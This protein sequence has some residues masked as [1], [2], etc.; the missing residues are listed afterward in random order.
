MSQKQTAIVVVTKAWINTSVRHLINDGR[1]SHS[2]GDTHIVYADLEGTSD[3]HGLW[4]R[5]IKTARLTADGSEVAMTRFMIPWTFIV[6]L[7]VVDHGAQVET[8]FA[9]GISLDPADLTDQTT[10]EV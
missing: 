5:N 7:G 10:R 1:E 2:T 4:L 3:H 8:G 9:G 6:A